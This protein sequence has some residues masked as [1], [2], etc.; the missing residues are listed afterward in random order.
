MLEGLEM[1]VEYV[2]RRNLLLDVAILA[3]TVP[4]L[5]RGVGR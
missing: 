1:D 5:L 4:T 2:Q 3:K